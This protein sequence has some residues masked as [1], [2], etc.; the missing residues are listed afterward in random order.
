MTNT[1]SISKAEW[2][3]I[4]VLWKKNPLTAQE[5]IKDLSDKAWHPRT[6]KTLITRL[7]KKGV[8][9]FKNEERTYLYYP[10]VKKNESIIDESQSF[11]DRFF[12]GSMAPLVAHF[13]ENKKLSKSEIDELMDI[14]HKSK[15]RKN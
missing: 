12:G 14:L 9:G 15:N 8:V 5:I 2:E 7:V 13:V 10:L 11:L 1:P 4:Q 3:I 6:I